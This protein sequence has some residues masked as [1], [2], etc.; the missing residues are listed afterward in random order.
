MKKITFAIFLLLNM[1][2]FADLIDDGLA[3]FAKRNYDKSKQLFKESCDGENAKGCLH[4]GAIY[5][6]TTEDISP[7]YKLAAEAFKKACDNGEKIACKK[8]EH[9]KSISKN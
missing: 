1:N 7:N 2:V 4:L 9:Y 5:L 3:E 8:Y 6:I